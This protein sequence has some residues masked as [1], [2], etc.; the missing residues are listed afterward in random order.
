MENVEEV[1]SPES[2]LDESKS[3]KKKPTLQAEAPRAITE[4]GALVDVVEA[5]VFASTEPVNPE[6]FLSLLEKGNF[7]AAKK[8]VKAAFGELVVRWGAEDKPLGVGFELLKSAGGYSFRTR[9]QFA[10]VLRAMLT[11]KP[12]RISKAHLECMSV[13]AY[14]QPVT[15]IEIEEIR[16]VDC[17]NSLRKLLGYGLVKIIGKSEAIGRPLLYGTT[18]RFLEFFGLNSLHDMPNLGDLETLDKGNEE[19]EEAPDRIVDLFA[20]APKDLVSEETNA[21][22]EEAV[23]ELEEALGVVKNAQRGFSLDAFDEKASEG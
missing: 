15:R 7:K 5:V 8:D 17:S 12:H 20:Q 2:S 13:I 16:G 10:P 21:L 14:R 6:S 1:G 18:K 4:V 22:S 9:E 23:N 19:V 11:E 3:R